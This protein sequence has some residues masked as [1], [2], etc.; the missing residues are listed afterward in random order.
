MSREVV[1]GTIS[2]IFA[3]LVTFLAISF[4]GL[5]EKN[6][7]NSQIEKIASTI[8]DNKEYGNTLIER[9]EESG[10]FKGVKR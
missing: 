6:I 9:M 1:T 7:T 5:L 8:V 3:S 2:A 10:R 4:T